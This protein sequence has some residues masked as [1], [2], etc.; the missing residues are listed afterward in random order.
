[1]ELSFEGKV[2]LVTGAGSGLGAHLAA[3]LARRGAAVL[4]NNRLSGSLD[5][6]G[7]VVDAIRAA[8]GRAQ[9]NHDDLSL[10]QGGQCAVDA[11]RRAFGRLDVAIHSAGVLRDRSLAKLTMTELHEVLDVHLLG[12]FHLA[13]PAFRAMKEQ[14]SGNLLFL[15]SA[16]GIFGNPGQA[17]YGAAKMGLLGLSNVLALEGARSGIRSNVIS[18]YAFTPATETFLRPFGVELLPAH[19]TPL[20]VVLA[21]SDCTVTQQVYSAGGGHFARIAV[22][23]GPGW[24]APHAAPPSAEEVASHMTQIGCTDPLWFPGSAEDEIRRLT[25]LLRS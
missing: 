7:E 13:L 24:T 5:K 15:S 2:A 6:A 10:E 25:T 4:V 11:A 22:G 21:S 16:A 18:P 12:A 14:G 8:G 20:M 3:E 23:L 17:N 9:A 19:V 1:M